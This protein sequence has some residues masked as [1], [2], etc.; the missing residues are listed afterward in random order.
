MWPIR[1]SEQNVDKTGKRK[2]Q[3]NKN[4]EDASKEKQSKQ[5]HF[6]KSWLTQR[7]W[8]RF[9][10][11]T[12]L[13]TCEYCITYVNSGKCHGQY[14]IS[15]VKGCSNYRT[16]AISD[17]EISKVHVDASN[18]DIVLKNPDQIRF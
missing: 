12:G 18:Y 2:K 13:M 11:E 7:P 1:W 4:D 8:L 9:N 14:S 6:N 15:F 10:E 16:S 5:R 3:N 17:H